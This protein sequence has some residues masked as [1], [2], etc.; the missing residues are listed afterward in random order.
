MIKHSTDGLLFFE[1]GQELRIVAYDVSRTNALVHVDGLGLLPIHFYIR[2][3]TFSQLENADW[4]GGVGT[5]SV[6][7]L[8]DGLMSASVSTNQ[9]DLC[10]KNNPLIQKDY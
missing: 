9:A 8:K 7:S 4:R 5:I 2:S 6:S 3:T 1:G 10:W